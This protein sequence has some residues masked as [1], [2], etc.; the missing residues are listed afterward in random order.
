MNIYSIYRRLRVVRLVFHMLQPVFRFWGH[1]RTFNLL[2]PLA[3]DSSPI[4]A[5]QN[6]EL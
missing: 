1:H 5:W 6:A 2:S 3:V 4:D